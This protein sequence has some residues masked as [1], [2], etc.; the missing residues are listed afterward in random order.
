MSQNLE[1]Q[2]SEI[3]R[4]IGMVAGFSRDATDWTATELGD[5]RAII[6]AGLRKFYHPP[7]VNGAIH[8]WRFLERQYNIA[9]DAA[10]STGTIAVAAGVVTLTGGTFPTWAD[11]GVLRYGGQTYYVASRDSATQVTLAQT[12]LT[13]TAGATYEM[14]R[15]RWPMP[16]D[17]AELIDGVVYSDGASRSRRLMGANEHTIRLQ[18]STNW[19]TQDTTKFAVFAGADTDAADW[20]MSFYPTL[21]DDSNVYFTY[22]AQP[23]DKLDATDLTDEGT[24]V[25]V[26]AAHAETVLAA[27]MAATEEYYNDE[28]GGAHGRRFIERLQASIAHDRHTAGPVEFDR[29]LDDRID[30][31]RYSLLYHVPTYNN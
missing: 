20:Y 2:N 12:G 16:S 3:L 1:L 15:W 14:V 31:R 26:P 19:R 11:D 17:F 6:R 21:A 23:L 8:Q 10:Y 22:R 24:T 5:A 27:I 9:A 13:V 18:F 7:L 30:R 25:Q 4:A 29:D 28:V